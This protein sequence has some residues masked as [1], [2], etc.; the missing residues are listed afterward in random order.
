MLGRTASTKAVVATFVILQRETP[1]LV[2]ELGVHVHV[3]MHSV[4]F[5][6]S[7]FVRRS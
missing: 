7:G 6:V 2:A 1:I 3:S 4:T 5:V